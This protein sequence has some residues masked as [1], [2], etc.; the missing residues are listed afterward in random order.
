[1]NYVVNETV[2]LALDGFNSIV[3]ER[4]SVVSVMTLLVSD[5]TRS[6]SELIAGID[7]DVKSSLVRS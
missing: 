4:V 2:L 7:S 3:L 1:M 6:H 5:K